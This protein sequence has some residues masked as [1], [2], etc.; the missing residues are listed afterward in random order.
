MF[1]NS[2]RTSGDVCFELGLD[3]I[4]PTLRRYDPRR[5][6]IVLQSLSLSVLSL[7][8]MSGFTP[9]VDDTDDT[10][11][12]PSPAIKVADGLRLVSSSFSSLSLIFIF[13]YFEFF[14][15]KNDELHVCILEISSKKVNKRHN[16]AI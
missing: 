7:V 1:N 6:V 8:R 16:F 13:D 5:V 9:E 11:P 4:L 14:S 15:S 10:S 12:A 2:T 3:F